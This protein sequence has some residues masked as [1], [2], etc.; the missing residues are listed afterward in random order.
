[1]KLLFSAFTGYNLRELL[2]PLTPLI[3]QDKNINEVIVVSPAA[4]YRDQLFAY[5]PAKYRFL[6]DQPGVSGYKKL[7]SDHQPDCVVTP[8]PGLEEKDIPLLQA[9]RQI[10][11]PTVTFIASWD[12]VYKLARRI[13]IRKYK[14]QYAVADHFAV[15]NAM[16][17]KHLLNIVPRLAP[18]QITVTGAP[19]L[20][21]LSDPVK[22]PSRETLLQ[23]LKIPDD[24]K[25][26][27][28]VASTELYPSD[29]I[30][31]AIADRG[32]CH[33]L[34]S[35]H[36]GGNITFH[37]RYAEPYRAFVR[38]SFGRRR[39]SPVPEFTYN[40]TLDDLR[41]HAALFLHS[42]LLINH[43]STVTIES[44]LADTPVI[45]V[46]YG[47][48]LDWW[49]WHRSMVYRDFNQH[50]R[51]IIDS[52]AT[53]VVH[54]RRELINAVAANLQDPAMHQAARRAL[55]IKMVTITDGTA[56]RRLLDLIKNVADYK[57]TP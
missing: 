56:G 25:K 5:L 4:P 8:T 14:Q 17:K 53:A 31:K 9:A 38:Y 42:D 48:P 46:K 2:L 20:D 18:Q 29:Y 55:A 44:L 41:L 36:P 54:S 7:L 19:R 16:N 37:R 35:V 24:G 15:W 50:A 39:H 3:N 13:K 28:H 57:G 45:N 10:G 32:D 22:I 27:I 52:G 21:F 30:I 1:M 49:R 6:T 33:I 34:L 23:R 51:I 11:I 43:S 26:L 40:P 12:N 47:K